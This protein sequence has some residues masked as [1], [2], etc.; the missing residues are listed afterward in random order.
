MK[1]IIFFY[2]LIKNDGLKSTYESYN[3]F[4]KSKF[5]VEIFS[6]YK[7]NEKKISVFYQKFN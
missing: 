6:L 4:L 7:F 2:P 1:K 5:K 3:S